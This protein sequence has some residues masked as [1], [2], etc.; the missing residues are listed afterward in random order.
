MKIL[1]VDSAGGISGGDSY[2]FSSNWPELMKLGQLSS[3]F[4]IGIFGR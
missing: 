2:Y 3:N 4:Q 1:G